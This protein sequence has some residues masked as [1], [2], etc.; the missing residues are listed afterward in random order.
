MACPASANSLT[1]TRRTY[2][3]ESACMIFMRRSRSASRPLSV[4][5]AWT[6]E[7]AEREGQGEARQ[8]ARERG[9]ERGEHG[10][11]A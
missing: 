11:H 7:R 8:T 6:P 10:E 3:S 5:I 2:A 9:R 4:Q 1:F